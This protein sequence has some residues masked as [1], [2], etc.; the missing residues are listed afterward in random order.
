MAMDRMSMAFQFGEG[1]VLR[2]DFDWGQRIVERHHARLRFPDLTAVVKNG[3]GTP[4]RGARHGDL[5]FAYPLEAHVGL[6]DIKGHVM[7]PGL[8]DRQGFWRPIP[9]TKTPESFK[10][11]VTADDE[12]FQIHDVTLRPGLLLRKAHRQDAHQNYLAMSGR[13]IW[14]FN[15]RSGEAKTL[16]YRQLRRPQTKLSMAHAWSIEIDTPH[17]EPEQLLGRYYPANELRFSATDALEVGEDVASWATTELCQLLGLPLREENPPVPWWESH[18]PER[19]PQTVF[20]RFEIMTVD[21]NP[22]TEDIPC[23]VLSP[24]TFNRFNAILVAQC[25]SVERDARRPNLSLPIGTL[26]GIAGRW[27]ASPLL[28]RGIY[29]LKNR[30]L[31][32]EPRVYLRDVGL[33]LEEDLQSLLEDWY[34]GSPPTS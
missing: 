5:W 34:H 25:V 11:W 8:L 28:L 20:K 12:Y 22:E 33:D 31:P 13:G 18:E 19:L 10:V 9:F 24:E 26:P 29:D 32:L 14:A 2:T 7:C 6:Y 21:F 3:E 15:T 23:V 16:R 4:P 27:L 1:T 30:A 17:D